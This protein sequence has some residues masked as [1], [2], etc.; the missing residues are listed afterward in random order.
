MLLMRRR[1]L[2]L[3][4][5]TAASA[6]AHNGPPFPIISDYRMG[7]CIISLWTHPDVGTG[8][9]F[10]IV[11]PAPGKTIPKDLKFEIGVLPVTGRLKEARYR[12]TPDEENGE[13]R[14]N[15][16]AQF[17]KQELWRVNLYLESKSGNQQAT[18]TVEVTPPGYGRWDLLFFSLPF[19][20]VGLLWFMAMKRKRLRRLQR[21]AS[22]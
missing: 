10:V 3:V 22:R 4:L 8:T 18:A 16:W 21:A 19:L 7:S 5:A 15:A 12:T 14:Y 6:C 13:I 2:L 17:D 9:F 1:L 20:G 11:G